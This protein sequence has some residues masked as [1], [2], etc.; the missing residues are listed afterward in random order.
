MVAGK[1][2]SEDWAQLL[3]GDP[4][5]VYPDHGSDGEPRPARFVSGAKWF[6]AKVIYDGETEMTTLA[7]W[8]IGLPN[9]RSR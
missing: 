9:V 3:R 8:R 6:S 4:I 5:L 1:W 7:A 2:E